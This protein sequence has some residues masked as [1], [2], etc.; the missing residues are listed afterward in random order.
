MKRARNRIPRKLITIKY[1]YIYDIHIRY[2]SLVIIYFIQ[3]SIFSSIHVNNPNTPSTFMEL[4]SISLSSTPPS[5]FIKPPSK[6]SK[7]IVSTDWPSTRSY[8]T[9]SRTARC[10]KDQSPLKRAIPNAV[11]RN[12]SVWSLVSRGQV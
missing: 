10:Q 12:I 11:C 5:I 3:L 1:N 2:S 6:I 7:G 9:S 8:L 4:A